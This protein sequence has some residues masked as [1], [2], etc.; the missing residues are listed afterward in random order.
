MG[1]LLPDA[2]SFKVKEI[3]SVSEGVILRVARIGPIAKCPGCGNESRR[4]HSRY[5]RM[6]QDLPFIGA[7]VRLELEVRRFVCSDSSC[8]QSI[9]AEPMSEI[10]EPYS[11]MTTR[12]RQVLRQLGGELGGM[13]AKRIGGQLLI[14][15]SRNTILRTLRAKDELKK[16]KPRV[17]GI[18]DF[19]FR[20]GKTYGSIIVDH[21]TRRVIDLLPN[22]EPETIAAWFAEH[23]EIE[24][25]TRDRG[26]PYIA[27]ITKGAPEAEQVADRFHLAQNVVDLLER[28]IEPHRKVLKA[29]TEKIRDL[30][31]SKNP[32]VQ[33]VPPPPKTSDQ[34]EKRVERFEQVR[35]LNQAGIPIAAISR[36]L[37][38]HRRDVRKFIKA[39]SFPERHTPEKRRTLIDQYLPYLKGRWESGCR[40]ASVLFRE[41][42][43]LGF[44]GSQRTVSKILKPWK[45]ALP[46][47]FQKGIAPAEV[48]FRQPGAKKLAWWLLGTKRPLTEL[49]TAFRAQILETSPVIATAFTQCLEF[50]QMMRERRSQDLEG[51]VARAQASSLAELQS[52][53]NGIRQDL[54]AVTAGFSQTWSNGRVEGHVNRLKMIKRQMYGR[55]NFDLLKARVVQTASPP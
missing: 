5:L 46:P 49:E 41:I 38:M 20:R 24:T 13:A 10:A 16:T 18:D 31:I 19:A 15:T 27:G 25:V 53:A 6:M 30:Q 32:V 4:I 11:R 43:L 3:I 2:K 45:S 28:L 35:A 48:L 17:V 44:E 33:E 29:V 36:R 9:F 52:F 1:G 55:A 8:R 12:L 50:L 23:P 21:E 47:E 26:N 54:A 22:R 42:R 40:F 51:W 39:D 7:G 37:G 34:R 14:K